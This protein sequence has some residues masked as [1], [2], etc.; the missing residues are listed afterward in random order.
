MALLQ[1]LLD[2]DGFANKTDGNI[3]YS[4]SSRALAEDFRWLVESLGGTARIVKHATKLLP[5]YRMNV[6][7]ANEIIPFRL[8]RKLARW[9]PRTKY[10]PNRSIMAVE[11]VGEAEVV[12]LRVD[13][14]F[15]RSVPVF[16]APTLSFS[17][18]AAA[19]TRL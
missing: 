19:P 18:C 8:A 4:S 5:S 13:A 1:G 10:L 3:E 12:C 9:Q 2:T 11:P 7:L 6:I 16:W 14:H 17:H 15:L